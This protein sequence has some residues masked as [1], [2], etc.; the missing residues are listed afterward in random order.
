MALKDILVGVDPSTAGEGRLKLALNLVRVHKAHI[1]ACCVMR[2]EHAAPSPI[3]P[4]VPVNPGP[5]VLIAPEATA[6]AGDATPIPASPAS[7]EAERAEQAEELF[8]TELRAHG[9][10]GEWHLLSPGETAVFIELAKSFDLTILG[11]LSPEIRSTGFRPDEIVIATGRPVLVVPYAGAFDM[12][13]RRALVA[14]DGTREAARAANDALPLLEDAETVTV[15]FVGARETLLAEHH[16]LIERMVHH[17]QRHGIPARA[18][19]TL[20]GDLRISDVLLSRAADLAADLI[21]AG[22]Y[23]HSQLREALVGGVSR[24]LLDHMTVPVLMSH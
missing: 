19:E 18:E 9:L 22:A 4:G 12:V 14:W 1:T 24:E 7:R 11:Q 16:P 13:G 15:M 6:T 3:L 20:Q 8:R 10:G 23:H 5:G 17:L 2:E 21:V